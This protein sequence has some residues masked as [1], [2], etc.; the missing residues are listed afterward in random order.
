MPSTISNQR[1]SS[2]SR[3][4]HFLCTGTALERC[5]RSAHFMTICGAAAEGMWGGGKST[6]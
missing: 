1:T 3:D 2:S 4:T 5:P 6:M